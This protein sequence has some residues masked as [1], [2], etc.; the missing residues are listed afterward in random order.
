MGGMETNIRPVELEFGKKGKGLE[1]MNCGAN[2]GIHAFQEIMMY[3]SLL[4][5]KSKMQRSTSRVSRVS[6]SAMLI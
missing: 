3:D 6:D 4:Y 5:C 1:W 2:G